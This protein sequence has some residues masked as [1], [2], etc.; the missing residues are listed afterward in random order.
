MD[1]HRS[2]SHAPID[3]LKDLINEM[4]SHAHPFILN[5]DC[6]SKGQ[7]QMLDLDISISFP[8][9]GS[10]GGCSFRLYNKPTSIW[11]PLS[12]A[13]RHPLSMHKHQTLAQCLRIAA[14]FSDPILAKE[15]IKALKA[16]YLNL[17]GVAVMDHRNSSPNLP[18]QST[19]WIVLPYSLCLAL[20]RL[21]SCVSSF[22]FP[23]DLPFC[24]ATNS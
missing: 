4:R 20:V 6:V 11:R 19:S 17:L 18:K 13:S 3:V 7:S 10:K 5:V 16:K 8:S 23:G 12:P 9:G 15:A 1:S 14:K 22:P 24:K 21:G 2:V